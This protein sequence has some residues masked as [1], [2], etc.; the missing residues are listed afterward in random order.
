MHTEEFGIRAGDAIYILCESAS[1]NPSDIYIV[2]PL[3]KKL[4]K[5]Y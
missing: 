2:D 5:T 4:K 1:L 3:W